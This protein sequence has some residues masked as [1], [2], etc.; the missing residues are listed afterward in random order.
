[1]G[2]PQFKVYRGKEYSAA[3]HHPEDAAMLMQGEGDTIRWGHRRVVWTEGEES[4]PAFESYDFVAAT[5]AERMK[6]VVRELAEASAK[7][8]AKMDAR[9]PKGAQ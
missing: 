3:C 8:K 9:Y 4:Q 7:N 2:Q 1:M 6:D 5:V